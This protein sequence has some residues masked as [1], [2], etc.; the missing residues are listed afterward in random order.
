MHQFIQQYLIKHNEC[1]I[2]GLGVLRIHQQG[3]R[4]HSADQQFLG[5]E[6]HIIFEEGNA[7]ADAFI[8]FLSAKHKVT[9]EYALE[10]CSNLSK[11]IHDLATGQQLKIA[12]AGYFT[13]NE[14]NQLKFQSI[15]L[16]AFYFPAIQPKRVIRPNALHTVKVGEDEVT[17]EQMTVKLN[18]AKAERKYQWWIG[19][20]C[21]LMV[22]I[23][24]II[25]FIY[26]TDGMDTFGN[27]SMPDIKSQSSTYQQIK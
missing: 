17:N 12:H 16:P 15:E 24:L 19:A 18:Q 9:K 26:Q 4:Y 21:L 11:A 20:A 27:S 3:A 6:L 14:E 23:A 5:P 7:D 25:V 13:K 2:M 1:P 22:A 8:S 10:W